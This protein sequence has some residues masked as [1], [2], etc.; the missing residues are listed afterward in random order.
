MGK[1]SEDSRNLGKTGLDI[2]LD[3]RHIESIQEKNPIVYSMDVAKYL[4]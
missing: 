4:T 3:R 2:A 1:L